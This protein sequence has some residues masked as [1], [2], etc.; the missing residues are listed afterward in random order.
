[1]IKSETISLISVPFFSGAIG[2]LTNWSG[3]WMLFNPVRFKGFRLPGLAPLAGLLPRKIQQIPG[4]MHGGVGW[5]GIIP[6]RAAKMGS[7]AVDK[8]I[9]KLGTPGDFYEQLEPD[10]IAEHILDSA[11]DDVR[12]VV[13]RT[14]EREHPTLWR[15]LPPR[16]RENVHERVQ[17]QLPDIIRDITGEIGTNIDQLLDVK[18]MVIRRFEEEP[19]VANRIFL[20]MGRKELRFIVNFG[21]WFGFLLGIPTA[22]LTEL[23][24][25]GAWWLLP[26]CG[27]LIGYT[28]NLLGIWMIFEPVEP[29]RLL[30]RTYQGL[31]LKRQAE[32][33]DIYSG[34]IADEIVTLTNIGDELLN[35]PRADRTRRMIE[36]AIHPAVD[37]AAGRAR[38]VVRVAMGTREYDSIQTS[39]AAETVDYAVKPFQ[40]EAFSEQQSRRVRELL[41]GRMR[42]M[43]PRDFSEMMRTVMRE[44]E[45]LLYLHGAVLG[46]GAGLIHL[47]LFG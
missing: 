33:S 35:G 11:R 17:E 5:Q 39:V 32:V 43:A 13:E 47:G 27:V 45:W 46:F 38:G 6:S 21:F 19:E 15:D 18:L 40:D 28:T 25:P 2:Y 22:V 3:V 20:E 24:F 4:V 7:I 30:G 41:A 10:K 42:E 36:T 23:L 9:A 44:D 1:M 16:L 29:R 26:I 37:R 12:D 8:G 14:M 34:I 31:F